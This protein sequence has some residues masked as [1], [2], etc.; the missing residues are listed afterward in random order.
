MSSAMTLGIERSAVE[1][2]VEDR[3]TLVGDAT[4]TRCAVSPAGQSTGVFQICLPV[5]MSI[6]TVA[7]ALVTYITP[8]EHQRLRLLAPMDC[9][10]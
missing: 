5:P 7:L 10:G 6:A 8:V 3:G 1:L 2:A 9:R 4:D